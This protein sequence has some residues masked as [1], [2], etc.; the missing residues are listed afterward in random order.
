M[1]Q[2]GRLEESIRRLEMLWFPD[3]VPFCQ[4]QFDIKRT[5]PLAVLQHLNFTYMQPKFTQRGRTEKATW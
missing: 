3:V 5:I 1:G 4:S 2:R